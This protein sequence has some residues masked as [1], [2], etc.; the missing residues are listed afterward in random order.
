MKR[1][2]LAINLNKNKF[3]C[4]L[5]K[6]IIKIMSVNNRASS[7][8]PFLDIDKNYESIKTES[9]SPE[10]QNYG[11]HKNYLNKIKMRLDNFRNDAGTAETNEKKFNIN[12][13][14][15]NFMEKL[16]KNLINSQNLKSA[17]EKSENLTLNTEEEQRSMTKRSHNSSFIS[18]IP[19]ISFCHSR[20][21]SRSLCSINEFSFQPKI[22]AKSSKLAKNQGKVIDRL[23]KPSKDIDHKFETYSYR[24]KLNKV[25]EKLAKSRSKSNGQDIWESLY[26]SCKEVPI[27]NENDESAEIEKECTFRPK[28]DNPATNVKAEDTIKRLVQWGKN[29]K[30]MKKEKSIIK[31]HQELKECSFT[32][33]ISE[34]RY[35]PDRKWK[36]KKDVKDHLHRQNMARK[37]KQE[38]SELETSFTKNYDSPVQTQAAKTYK[39]LSNQAYKEALKKLHADL[40]SF[41]LKL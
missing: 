26:H 31:L 24:P 18:D 29:V 20:Y 40:H 4:K 12:S 14:T 17:S 16:Q 5:K 21:R 13:N 23:L 2:K 11:N 9:P 41:S 25:S 38:Q 36:E 37:I 7:S 32:P 3:S 27:I 39:D 6:R 30:S 35:S 28:I 19:E 8:E 10:K 22:S 15:L 34:M 1:H 33:S